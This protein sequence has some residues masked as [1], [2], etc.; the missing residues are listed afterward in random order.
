MSAW[1]TD[2]LPIIDPF[3]AAALGGSIRRSDEFIPPSSRGV[4]KEVEPRRRAAEG[5]TP[6]AMLARLHTAQNEHRFWD[7]RVFRACAAGALTKDDFRFLFSQYYLYTQSFT[8]YLAALMANCESDLHR[9]RLAENIWEEGGGTAPERRHAQ[10]FR[11]FLREGLGA[12]VD[13]I[14]F[15]DV[16]RFFVREYLDF[17]LRSHPTAASAFLSLGTEGIVPRMYAILVDGL[18]KAGVPE[19]HIAFFRIHMECDDEHAE[20]LEQIMLSYQGTPDWLN[21]CYSSMDYAL[22]LRHRFFEQLFDAMEMRRLRGVID[23][24]QRGESLAPD[25]PG[26]AELRYR[27]GAPALPLYENADARLGIDFSVE[28]VP[29]KTDVCDARVLRVAAHQSNERHKHPHES[30]LYVVSGR[31]RMQVN[32]SSVEVEPGDLVFVPR[33][34]THQSHNTGDAELTIL[35]VTDYGL[36]EKT[37]VG[38]QLRATRLKGTQAPREA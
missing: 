25:A 38:N 5:M 34:A 17:C 22:S 24:V 8:R 11:G 28:R 33:W 10:I 37:Y 31:G 30:L 32:R 7:N 29:F 2:S 15:T 35:A 26:P 12:D 36:T 9:S 16:T 19:A 3:A 18:L 6:D 14:D 21:T 23:R 27:V 4:M 20:T 1:I 13:D